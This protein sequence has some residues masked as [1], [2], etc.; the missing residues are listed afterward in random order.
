[1]AIEGNKPVGQNT[2]VWL[3]RLARIS[4]W[5]LFA[6]VAVL[7]ISGWGITQ[8]GIIYNITFGLVDRRLADAIHRA[9]IL[10]MVFFFLTHV[11]I[12]IILLRTF[13]RSIT[14]RI[15]TGA[16]IA[17]GVIVLGLVIYMEY[18]RLGG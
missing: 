2:R 4:S 1:M 6:S 11:F 12:N 15:V 3:K 14:R 18:F 9:S 7:V 13:K 16:L 8:T 17:I 5:G 10:P